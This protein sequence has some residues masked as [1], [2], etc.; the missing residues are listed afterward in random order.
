MDDPSERLSY[1]MALEEHKAAIKAYND[2]KF[3]TAFRKM[4][5][6]AEVNEWLEIQKQR[7]GQQYRL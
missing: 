4:W 2:L 7:I 6:A 5:T 3:P 1:L